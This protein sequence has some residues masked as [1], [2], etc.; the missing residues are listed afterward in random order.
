MF[1]GI[2][3]AASRTLLLLILLLPVWREMT[4]YDV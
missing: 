2:G 1:A 3:A 4:F